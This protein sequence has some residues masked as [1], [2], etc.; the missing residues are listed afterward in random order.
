MKVGLVD[1]L[2]LQFG[3]EVE[4]RNALIALVRAA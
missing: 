1:G 2:E 3:P 4:A